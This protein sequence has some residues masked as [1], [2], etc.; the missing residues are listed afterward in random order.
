MSESND[1]N[2]IFNKEKDYIVKYI[3]VSQ[4][5]MLTLTIPN[6][7]KKVKIVITN[8]G[9]NKTIVEFY[10]SYKIEDDK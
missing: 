4:S 6:E 7:E 10:G 5:M 1:I 9:D 3:P 2:S 8:C